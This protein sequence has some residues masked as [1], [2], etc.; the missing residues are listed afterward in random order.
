MYS[1]P[2]STDIAANEASK[3]KIFSISQKKDPRKLPAWNTQ[4]QKKANKYNS[5]IFKN[6]IKPR[7]IPENELRRYNFW[8]PKIFSQNCR[9]ANGQT[10]GSRAQKAE[11]SLRDIGVRGFDWS[12]REGG[13]RSS[14]SAGLKT[15]QQNII[16][17]HWNQSILSKQDAVP[18]YHFYHNHL[19]L[20]W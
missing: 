19:K 5:R 20:N 13:G 17:L 18:F 2:K 4:K 14:C 7:K 12:P 9:T 15:R 1:F 16:S 6:G 8:R 11:P 3:L 10:A